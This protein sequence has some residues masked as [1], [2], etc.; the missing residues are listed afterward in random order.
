MAGTIQGTGH[1]ILSPEIICKEAL[2]RLKRNTVFPR[3]V[4]RARDEYFAERIGDTVT[5]KKPYKAFIT[6]GPTITAADINPLVDESVEMKIEERWK[7][8]FRYG[9][10]DATL[11]INDFYNRYMATAI[12][13]LSI[14]YELSG[15]KELSDN[16]FYTFGTPGTTLDIDQGRFARAFASVMHIPAPEGNWA[17]VNPDDFPRLDETLGGK[18]GE[19]NTVATMK[20]SGVY[21]TKL[22]EGAL[23]ERLMGKWSYFELVEC[24][25]IPYYEPGAHGGTPLINGATQSGSSITTDGWTA[26]TKV[27]NKGALIKIAG[28]NWTQPRGDHRDTGMKATFVVTEDVTSSAAG[29]ATIKI[30]P[31]INDGTVTFDDGAD[32]TVANSGKAFKNVTSKAADNAVITV[33]GDSGAKYRQSF[34]FQRRCIEHASVQLND[35]GGG[36]QFN[37]QFDPQ[38]GLSLSVTRYADGSKMETTTRADVLYGYKMVYPEVAMRYIGTKIS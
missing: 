13:E 7:T 26:S 10:R 31:P 38:T 22:V 6:K 2:F 18:G 27:L 4:T 28:I 29:A 20:H 30:S 37:R 11:L 8:V 16:T 3:L 14:Q 33:V 9:D 5:I 12:E 24:N 15:C 19:H 1:A 23:R 32:N 36:V 35:I 17:L 21:S 25:S 34:F